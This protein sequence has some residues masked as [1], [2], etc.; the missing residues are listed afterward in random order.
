MAPPHHFPHTW[1][2]PIPGSVGPWDVIVASD[3]LLY[4]KAYPALVSTLDIL[5]APPDSVFIMS[6]QRRL[7]ES[8]QF[9][10]LIM[11]EGF[12]CRH[13]GRLIFEIRGPSSAGGGDEGGA[14]GGFETGG[15]GRLAALLAAGGAG[16][17]PVRSGV[18]PRGREKEAPAGE[19][20]ASSGAEEGGGDGASRA[21]N[22]GCRQPQ[23]GDGSR[24]RA[25]ADD[26]AKESK[27][28]SAQEGET[29]GRGAQ[30]QQ[31]D[32]GA[33]AAGAGR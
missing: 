14:D 8:E 18:P 13:L 4:V 7:P 26:E 28:S 33:A 17:S 23:T 19:K 15:K 5:L 2:A 20:A 24:R 31:G 22:G 9:F 30:Q 25:A 3:I 29:A 11:A 6:W 16:A 10:D 21:Q 27:A 32:R 1:G 12:R